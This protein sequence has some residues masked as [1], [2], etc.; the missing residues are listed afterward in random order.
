LEVILTAVDDELANAWGKFCG[1]LPGVRVH[2]GSILDARCDAV[3]SPAN[4][5][6]FMDGGI[7]AL[8]RQRFGASIESRLR[9]IIERRHHGE[10]LVGA[11][12]ILETGDPEI[13]YL[14]A[15]PTMRFPWC[16]VIPSI[17]IW[18]RERRSC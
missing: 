13:P 5:L 7:D 4:S 8:Y 10:L 2:R 15:A 12:E 16:F 11:A 18:L 17:H 1:D 6:G 14:I 9:E 3:V